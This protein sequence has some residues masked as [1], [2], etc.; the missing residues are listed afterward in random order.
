MSRLFPSGAVRTRAVSSNCTL[1]SP[2]VGS[3]SE[4]VPFPVPRSK[5]L[6]V[7]EVSFPMAASPNFTGTST[8]PFS[9]TCTT[10][11]AET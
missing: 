11:V 6:P 3:S 4:Y 10:S 5:T 2:G 9:S 1:C 7:S 8:H